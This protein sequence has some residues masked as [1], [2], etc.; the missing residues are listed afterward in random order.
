M[1]SIINYRS[2][3]LGENF[4]LQYPPNLKNQKLEIL[5]SKMNFPQNKIWGMQFKGH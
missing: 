4:I 1:R 5:R 3:I 2:G